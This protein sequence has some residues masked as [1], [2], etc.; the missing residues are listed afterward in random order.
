M[1]AQR[2]KHWATG[3]DCDAKPLATTMTTFYHRLLSTRRVSSFGE[4]DSDIFTVQSLAGSRATRGITTYSYGLFY[5]QGSPFS[6]RASPVHTSGQQSEVLR[7]RNVTK[8]S[9]N[10]PPKKTL[11]FPMMSA[12]LVGL[13]S[14]V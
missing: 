4:K 6:M 8:E 1:G 13:S 3:G 9:A 14:D 5:E 10:P 12:V 11:L 7:A 2:K